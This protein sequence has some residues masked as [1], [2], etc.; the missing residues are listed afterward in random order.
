MCALRKHSHT[1][2]LNTSNPTTNKVTSLL[3]KV[4]KILGK[5]EV[6]PATPEEIEQLKLDLQREQLKLNIAKTKEE[7]PKSG[8]MKFLRPKE[9]RHQRHEHRPRE[10]HTK[11]QRDRSEQTFNDKA[12]RISKAIGDNKDKM[13]DLK[14]G[15]GNYIK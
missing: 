5:K 7:M 2:N 8:L 4:Q 13:K 11:P 3:R 12:E 6:K 9:T 15:F 14:R 10:K 1:P